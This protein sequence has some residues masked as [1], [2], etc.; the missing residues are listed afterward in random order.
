MKYKLT[1]VLEYYDIP[2]TVSATFKLADDCRNGVCDFSI[3]GHFHDISGCC[4]EEIA[5]HFPEL[6]PFIPLHLSNEFGQ[7]MYPVDNFIFHIRQCLPDEKIMEL[8]RCN[9]QQLSDLR[10]AVHNKDYFKY[11]LYKTGLIAKW[12]QDADVAIKWLEEKTGGKF[13]YTESPKFTLEYPDEWLQQ[14]EQRVQSGEFSSKAMA[15]KAKVEL[16]E[17]QKRER[18]EAEIKYF[19]EYKSKILNNEIN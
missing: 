10:N 12:K 14:M 16:E 2:V 1:K 4:H 8:Y 15:E 3:T 18:L 9:E 5:R 6:K 13:T 11:V 19:G 7:P 17:W